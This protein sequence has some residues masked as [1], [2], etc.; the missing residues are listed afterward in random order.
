MQ[1]LAKVKMEGSAVAQGQSGAIIIIITIMSRL[2][3]NSS[4]SVCGGAGDSSG[5][6][7]C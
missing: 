3:I 7:F 4:A 2:F 5:D 6:C 1:Q